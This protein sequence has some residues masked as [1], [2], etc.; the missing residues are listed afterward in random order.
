MRTLPDGLKELPTVRKCPN[1]G[2][3]N[4]FSFTYCYHCLEK[5]GANVTTT[6]PRG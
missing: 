4:D 1:C 6:R 3:E 5:L 2:T